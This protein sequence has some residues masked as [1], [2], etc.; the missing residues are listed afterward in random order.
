V[1]SWLHPRKTAGDPH[2]CPL[3]TKDILRIDYS[4]ERIYRYAYQKK[5]TERTRFKSKGYE[6]RHH[7]QGVKGAD[8]KT[9]VAAAVLSVS[10][11]GCSAFNDRS[12]YRNPVGPTVIGDGKSVMV[13]NA[14]NE[15]EGQRLA[16]KHCK[17]FGKSARFNRMEGC[18]HFSIANPFRKYAILQT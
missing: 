4:R 6:P 13:S 11:C 5:L 16:E 14:Q 3:L 8:L 1:R 9:I 12:I 18:E 17:R 2:L 7:A 15:S 10:L